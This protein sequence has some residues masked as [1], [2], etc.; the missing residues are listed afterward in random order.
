MA[1]LADIWLPMAPLPDVS[2]DNAG[3]LAAELSPHMLGHA[4]V[5]RRSMVDRLLL[6]RFVATPRAFTLGR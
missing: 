6:G 1:H 2:S 3:D 5:C 4:R